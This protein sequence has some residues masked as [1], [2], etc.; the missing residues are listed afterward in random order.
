L[1]TKHTIG[2]SYKEMFFK[3]NL[4]L[5]GALFILY[6]GYILAMFHR[7]SIAIMADRLIE[8]LNLN[9][10]QMT[11]MAAV[12]FYPYALMQF[13]VGI[14][15]DRI[16][17]KRLVSA[18][19]LLTSFASIIF[20]FATTFQLSI[21]SRLL[22]GLSVSCIFVPT[23]KF[24]ASY[25]PA[26]IFSTLTSLLVFSGIIGILCASVP[27]AFLVELL[28]WRTVYFMMGVIALVLSFATWFLLDDRQMLKQS[29]HKPKQISSKLAMKWVLSEWG[30]W[31]IAIR[32]FFGYGATMAFQSLWAGPY[33][34]TILGMNRISA[35][36]LIMLLSLGQLLSLPFS[37]ILSDKIFHSRKLPMLIGSLGSVFLWIP[38]TF[39]TS[40]LLTWHI[41]LIFLLSGLLAGISSGPIFT[42][43]KELY[44]TPLTGTAIGIGN[45]FNMAGAAIIPLLCSVAMAQ[46]V[47]SSSALTASSFAIGFRYLLL[48]YGIAALATIFSK[49]TSLEKNASIS[50]EGYKI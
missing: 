36:Y 43:M 27:L 50:S 13:P 37:G 4:R 25:F 6:L 20:A 18:M 28:D 29:E 16:G 44:P 46:S 33:L 1:E 19:L 45:F 40:A 34:M 11:I 17:P 7:V 8:D 10:S 5:R 47:Q 14:L 41:A 23:E 26:E 3:V 48:A 49:D 31:P 12:Y 24:I 42:L 2:F 38:F 30:M 9:L 15:V 35:G 22:I 32:N 39:Y 21:I